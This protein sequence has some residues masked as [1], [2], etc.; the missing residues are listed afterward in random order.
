MRKSQC[1]KNQGFELAFHLNPNCSVWTPT[2]LQNYFI[3]QMSDFTIE[4][5]VANP[6]ATHRIICLSWSDWATLPITEV[7]LGI[8]LNVSYYYWPCLPG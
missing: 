2:E 6:M 1:I 8:R 4:F 7:Q 3:G 5:Y